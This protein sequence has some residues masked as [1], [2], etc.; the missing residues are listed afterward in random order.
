MYEIAQ[1][2]LNMHRITLNVHEGSYPGSTRELPAL[3]SLEGRVHGICSTTTRTRL[4]HLASIPVPIHAPTH[5]LT[6]VRLA[7]ASMWRAP[8]VLQ[9]DGQALSHDLH[10]VLLHVWRVRW[11]LSALLPVSTTS[12]ASTLRTFADAVAA[13]AAASRPCLH[14]RS[15][16]W[17]CMR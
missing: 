1:N 9:I 3:R 11:L 5:Q 17:T 2:R 10:A 8:K 12:R 14:V 6:R 13:S 7:Q 16:F 4:R 15:W